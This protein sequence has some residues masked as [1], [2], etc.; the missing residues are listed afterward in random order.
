M[1]TLLRATVFSVLPL[2]AVVVCRAATLG[3]APQE[4]NDPP[5]S[6]ERVRD[7]LAKTPARRFDRP[8]DVPIATFKSSV[9][10]RIYVSSFEEW[11]D[12]E[13]RLTALQRQSADWGAKCCGLNLISLLKRVDR[14]LERRKVRKIREE[15]ARELAQLE[16][17]KKK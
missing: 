9:R 14:A 5:L 15:I 16:A 8:L 11:L 7:G 12:K 6:L 1:A 13:F 4:P 2:V 10:Q 3:A 17:A